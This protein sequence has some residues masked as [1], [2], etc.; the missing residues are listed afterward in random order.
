MAVIYHA[1]FPPAEAQERFKLM[2]LSRAVVVPDGCDERMQGQE[3][4]IPVYLTKHITMV[5]GPV[6]A[7]HE[8]L[9]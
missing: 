1:A 7:S 9:L 4:S 6:S 3:I 8:W 5:Q 2:G